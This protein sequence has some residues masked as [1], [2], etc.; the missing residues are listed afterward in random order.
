M[1]Y[2]RKTSTVNINVN[3]AETSM[4]HANCTQKHRLLHTYVAT[5]NDITMLSPIQ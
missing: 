2:S 5:Y 4:P 1:Q 3:G